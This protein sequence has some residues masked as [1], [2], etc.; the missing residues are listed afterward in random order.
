MGFWYCQWELGFDVANENWVLDIASENWTLIVPMRIE[1]WCCQ[2][3]L[4][5]DVANK[6]W[7]LMFLI[8]IE[9]WYCQCELSFGKINCHGFKSW[10]LIMDLN[11]LDK[12]AMGLNHGL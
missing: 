11:S 6:N 3:K 12:I 7:D 5:F 4:G 9:F 1:F 2:W 8:R 10:V